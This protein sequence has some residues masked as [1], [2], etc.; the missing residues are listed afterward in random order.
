MSTVNL[1]ILHGR[2]G[3]DPELKTTHGGQSL[4][5]FSLATEQTWMDRDGEKQKTTEWHRC[6][7]WGRRA[8]ALAKM[9]HKGQGL[10]VHGRLTYNK[11]E[12]KNGQARVT[13]QIRVEELDFA[14][15]PKKRGSTEDPAKALGGGSDPVEDMEDIPF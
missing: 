5:A 2:L 6:V 11:W 12:D 10:V 7:L 13:A 4:L 15:P 1:V 9:L 3:E 8:E 14:A